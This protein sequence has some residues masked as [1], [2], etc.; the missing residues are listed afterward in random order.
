MTSFSYK[1]WYSWVYNKDQHEDEL[2]DIMNKSKK[3]LIKKY[4]DSKVWLDCLRF[5]K[6]DD[7]YW[8]QATASGWEPYRRWKEEKAMRLWIIAIREWLKKWYNIC[9]YSS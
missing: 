5:V 9:V 8:Y 4:P 6:N 1:I 3:L 7:E 2:H